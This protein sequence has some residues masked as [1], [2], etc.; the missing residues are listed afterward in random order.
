MAGPPQPF[1]DQVRAQDPARYLATLY[2]PDAKRADLLTLHAFDLEMRRIPLLV[3]EPAMGEIRQ[4]WWNE[5]LQ[6][7]RAGEASGHPLASAMLGL[8]RR[9]SLPIAAFDRYFDASSFAFYHDVF[10]DRQA[11]EAW[12]GATSST[13]AQMA[14]VILDPDA[15]KGS[16][17]A[18]G[19]AGVALAISSILHDLPRTRAQGQCYLPEDMLLA[20]GLPRETY[21]SGHDR[22]AIKR[23]TDAL[24]A[25]GLEHAT[26]AFRHL[27][28]TPSVLKPAYLALGAARAHLQKCARPAS[29]PAFE[30][31]RLSALSNYISILRAAF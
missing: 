4:Q 11:L 12:A 15:A 16:S 1:A 21:M 26:K 7:D 20:C 19:H 18:S 23:A 31:V 24:A 22:A 10:A 27:G 9:H 8:I 30:E 6:G 13:I 17:D 28:N 29:H 3:K 2:A 14:A 25:F 5:V